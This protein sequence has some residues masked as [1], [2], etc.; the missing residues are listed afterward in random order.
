MG[1]IELTE[2]T[3]SA[4]L[5]DP[6][7]GMMVH[8]AAVGDVNGDGW[9]DLFVGT[10]ADRPEENY[11]VR[12]SEGISPDRLMLGGP[13]G[14][15]ADES[16]PEMY[17]RT[18]GS[19]FADLNNNGELDLVL[20]RNKNARDWITHETLVLRNDGGVFTESTVLSED[21]RGRSIAVLDYDGDGL[22]D[23]FI[24]DDHYGSGGDSKL[25]RNEGDF[26]FRDVTEEVGL[27]TGMTGLGAAAAD[28]NGDGLPD[29]LLSGTQRTSEDG[30]EIQDVQV[31]RMFLNTGGEFQEA[32]ASAFQFPT[33]TTTD[34]VAGLAVADLNRDGLLDVVQASHIH[35]GALL[36]QGIPAFKI[37]LNR[38]NDGD[39][40]PIFEDVTDDAGIPDAH[41]RV[42]HVEI[43]DL[44]ADGWP[45]IVTSWSR[46]DGTDVA[47]FRNLG[48][49][50]D[51]VE[52]ETPPGLGDERTTP[53]TWSTWEEIGLDRYW[54]NGAAADFDRDG[55]ID[56]FVSEWFPELPSRLFGNETKTG[57]G[58]FVEVAPHNEAIGAQ[59]DVYCPGRL[60]DPEALVGSRPLT[61]EVG[62]GAGLPAELFFGLGE[63]EVVDVRVTL[64]N[65]GGVI[66]QR[67]VRADQRVMLETHEA[68]DGG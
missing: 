30:S 63:A 18:S 31:A 61:L 11:L 9:L 15:T 60:G 26:E 37:Y 34:E 65:D 62:Y 17:G 52:F 38:G 8:A 46:G 48:A 68:V 58:L 1:P 59:V 19:V 16:F 44:D 47:T 66:E 64:P 55:R 25:F 2:I 41:T 13:D 56:V 10:F 3:E 50:G 22:L 23:L 49:D 53:P 20:A 35:D 36:E 43:V 21:M 57:N 12:G 42:P 54:A 51:S 5:L 45:D 29:I 6:L 33:A 24:V 4:G 7:K 39:G 40:A 14:F 67:G 27:P 28:L 32:D